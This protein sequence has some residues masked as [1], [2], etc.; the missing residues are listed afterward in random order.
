VTV[1]TPQGVR[2]RRPVPGDL[3]AAADI[4]AAEE[5]ALRGSSAQGHAELVDWWR[6]F[7]LEEG[8]WLVEDEAGRAVGFSATFEHGDILDCWVCVRP[9]F[10]GRGIASELL[11]RGEERA[12]ALGKPSIHAGM[13]LENDAARRVLEALGYREVR[14]FYRMQVE[15]DGALEPPEWPAG[16]RAE[17]FRLEDARAFKDAIDEAFADDW[18]FHSST[19]EQWKENRLEAPET[20]TSL[21][22]IARDGEEIAGVIRCDGKRFGGGWVGALG[23]RKPWRRRGIGRAL[24]RHAFEEFRRRGEPHVG[25]GVDAENESGALGLYERAGMRAVSADVVFAKELT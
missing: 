9:E 3:G 15:L 16:I 17:T 4:L 1:S 23:V 21:W 13:L 25:L 18:G 2:F 19:F 7:D 11:R 5:E 6:R 24:L 22:F 8:S 12:R 14:R 10:V 20:D